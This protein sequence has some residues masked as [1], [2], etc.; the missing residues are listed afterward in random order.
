MNFSKK[1]LAGAVVAVGTAGA[2]GLGVVSAAPDSSGP[3][4]LVDKIAT[5]FN[6][7]KGEVRAVFDE[8]AATHR[9]EMEQK[10]E[11]NLDRAVAEGKITEEQKAKIVAKRA[12]MRTQA[13]GDRGA[14][15]NKTKEEMRTLLQERHDA[16]KQWATDNGIPMEYL[17][18]SGIAVGVVGEH[19]APKG[20]T[21]EMPKM[22]IHESLAN[23]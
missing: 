15:K 13:E 9:V 6:L 4:G 10:F 2:I 5:K 18:G 17:M 7:D 1:L 3:Q 23:E 11:G 22:V 8:D 12:E 20:G 14:F 16:L 19:H 21:G